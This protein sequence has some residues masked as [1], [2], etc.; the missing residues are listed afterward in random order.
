M[1]TKKFFESDLSTEFVVRSE[2]TDA[3]ISTFVNARTN[4]MDGGTDNI[5]IGKGGCVAGSKTFDIRAIDV[6]HKI[7][8][9]EPYGDL[10]KKE[11]L[12]ALNGNKLV[13]SARVNN[14]FDRVGNM[15]SVVESGDYLWT[16][17]SGLAISCDA[18]PRFGG[19]LIVDGVV[20]NNDSILWTGE[21][22]FQDNKLCVTIRCDNK[23]E[24]KLKTKMD[25]FISVKTAGQNPQF[26]ISIPLSAVASSGSSS[27]EWIDI[28]AGTVSGGQY[29]K[30][31][32]ENPAKVKYEFCIQ[33]SDVQPGIDFSKTICVYLPYTLP[34]NT[35][36]FAQANQKIEQARQSSQYIGILRTWF[37]DYPGFG[38][39]VGGSNAN[40][41]FGYACY[42]TGGFSFAT[43]QSCHATGK[44]GVAMGKLCNADGFCSF[45]FGQE[46][47]AKKLLAVAGGNNASSNFERAFCWSGRIGGPFEAA[48]T[49]TFNLYPVG[50][51]N[52]IYV[53]CQWNT[54][55][56][57]SCWHSKQ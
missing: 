28:Y 25:R 19:E 33:L 34:Q 3:L 11:I 2:A 48:G 21:S 50:G 18:V 31:E 36:T 35:S 56:L 45:A 37:P 17:I 30:K 32:S 54:A 13:Y 43:G 5:A 38:T 41:A 49:G 23:E 29:A 57:A 39:T 55:F 22:K 10:A 9:V 46:S 47:N 6:K 24:D 16:Q 12:G 44:Q 42:A 20:L 14:A 53:I 26:V 4:I 15:I 1:N 51:L 8:Y 7:L 52:G 40:A 27:G